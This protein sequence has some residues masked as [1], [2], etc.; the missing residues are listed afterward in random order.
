MQLPQDF[1]DRMKTQLGAEAD[2]FFHALE[3]PAPTSIRLN[4]FKGKTNFDHLEKVLWCNEG[5]Y[6]TER[7]AFYMDPHWHGGAYYVQEASSM[8]LDYVLKKLSLDE[9]PRIWLDVCAA[10][11]GKTG[12]LAKHKKDSD[13]LVANE[14]VPQRNSIL[15]ENMIKGGYL[16]TFISSEQAS[17]F[18]EPF[19]DIILIDAP[20][21]GEGMMR[22]DAEAIRQW[23]PG[24]VRDC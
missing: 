18:K 5:F 21:A 14:V 24:L 6:L 17:S 23:S 20:C 19:A 8:I 22:K 4:H 9:K 11:G 15:R 13:V 16:N 10:P 7:P 3:Q 1:V 2:A 12:I